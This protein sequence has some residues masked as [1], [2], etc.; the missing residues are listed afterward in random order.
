MVSSSPPRPLRWIIFG[1]HCSRRRSRRGGRRGRIVVVVSPSPSSLAEDQRAEACGRGPRLSP[2][3]RYYHGWHEG[4]QP[5]SYLGVFGHARTQRGQNL[6]QF[7]QRYGIA[8]HVRYAVA[9]RKNTDSLVKGMI[10][11]DQGGGGRGGGKRSWSKV[12]PVFSPRSACF[13]FFFR[14]S[15]FEFPARIKKNE[16]NGVKFIRWTPYR[17]AHKAL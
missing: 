5:L 3:L 10:L 4:S 9:S 2:S 13:S 6:L 7:R 12:L 14:S 8:P 16:K 17:R 1:R 15:N 11:F